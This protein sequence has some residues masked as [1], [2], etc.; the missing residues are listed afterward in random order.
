MCGR[1]MLA[2]V[3]AYCAANPSRCLRMMGVASAGEITEACLRE[4]EVPAVVEDAQDALAETPI[5]LA[6]MR[7]ASPAHVIYEFLIPL[8]AAE[9]P[10]DADW[11]DP[12]WRDFFARGIRDRLDWLDGLDAPLEFR[13]A[14]ALVDA[15]GAVGDVECARAVVPRGW[16]AH[17]A[18]RRARRYTGSDAE[19]LSAV[20][21]GEMLARIH[22]TLLMPG[23]AFPEFATLEWSVV[24]DSVLVPVLVA[25]GETERAA[26]RALVVRMLESD[27]AMTIRRAWLDALDDD[28]VG[29]FASELSRLLSIVPRRLLPA[30]VAASY[31]DDAE[32][33]EHVRAIL[34]DVAA[35]RLVVAP[36]T[37]DALLARLPSA[38]FDAAVG[39]SVDGSA[40]ETATRA[41]LGLRELR[42]SLVPVALRACSSCRLTCAAGCVL[43]GRARAMLSAALARFRADELA[44]FVGSVIRGGLVADLALA[45][46]EATFARMCGALGHARL[47]TL[48]A[49]ID[50]AGAADAAI[51]RARGEIERRL[52]S[53][54]RW[55]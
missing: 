52:F 19:L 44:T 45:M 50:R 36:E 47:A 34:L 4:S 9:N 8:I 21:G 37:L 38:M 40:H 46:D 31:A 26:T 15:I 11:S 33:G 10:D 5:A 3:R 2:A 6:C 35:G 24:V 18:L 28:D 41:A 32:V 54:L 1:V 7:G 39:G 42:A 49:C 20:D 27:D 16:D 13:A 55:Q 22:L 43:Y 29:R 25:S 17:D 23:L 12:D 30:L 14:E 51:A 53:M 48:L